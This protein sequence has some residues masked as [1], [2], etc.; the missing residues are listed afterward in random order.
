[1]RWLS[2]LRLRLRSLFQR[3]AV[4]HELDSEL[5]FHIEQQIAEN[6]ASGMSPD[7]AKYAA[8]RAMGGMTQVAEQCREARN[9]G[10]LC[11]VSSACLE[12]YDLMNRYAQSSTPIARTD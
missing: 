2:K 6:L 4:E 1:M 11:V 10:E 5:R 3:D 9:V 12:R 8:L 7:E